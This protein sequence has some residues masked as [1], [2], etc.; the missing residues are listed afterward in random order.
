MAFA[1]FE[2]P[3]LLDQP[4]ASALNHLL[5]AEPWARSRLLPFGGETVAFAAPP[6]PELRLSI[7]AD[8]RV[9]PAAD[10]AARPSLTLTLGSEALAAF[11][12]GEEHLM[13]AVEVTGNARLASEVMLL[14]RHLRWDP[15]EDL[16][17]LVGEVAARRLVAL[18][19]GFL[20][21]QADAAQRLAHS[22]V[23]YAVEE[24]RIV[25]PRSELEPLAAGIAR[26]RDAIERLEKRI[27][28][29]A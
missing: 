26:L 23:E 18:A 25:L 28:R 13:R 15:E 12:R 7:L 5:D 6:L 3:M 20:G 24:E 27:E 11:A 10:D 16:S 2:C 4:F 9:S 14:V 21:W 29:I 22:L 8:G 19:R 1:F 17:R